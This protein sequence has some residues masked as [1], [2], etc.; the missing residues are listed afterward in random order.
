M[1]TPTSAS[2]LRVARALLGY[3]QRQAAEQA[4]VMQKAIVQAEDVNST[5]FDINIHLVSFY[6]SKGIE[7]VGETSFGDDISGSGARWKLPPNFPASTDD[8]Q[9]HHRAANGVSFVA[10]RCLLGLNRA[11]VA[12]HLGFSRNLMASLE[13]STVWMASHDTLRAFYDSKDVEFLGWGEAGSNLFYGLG[14]RWR[15]YPTR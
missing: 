11:E 2:A 3:T 14:V 13:A 5:R 12:T 15:A 1:K 4:G 7:F 6:K 8:T 10:A 9:I